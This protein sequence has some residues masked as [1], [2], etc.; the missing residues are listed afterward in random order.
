MEVVWP[1]RKVEVGKVMSWFKYKARAEQEGGP[2]SSCR[3][4]T[5]GELRLSGISVNPDMWT[6]CTASP[7]DV[8]TGRV[9]GATGT[10]G[11]N[12]WANIGPRKYQ[13][14]YP[15][16]GLTDEENDAKNLKY[17]Y[18]ACVVRRSRPD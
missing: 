6:P 15:S 17:F 11:E 10:A 8:T 12:C 16:W 13:T 3:L 5:T 2:M 4:P 7:G 9:D 1:L 14:E 18:V